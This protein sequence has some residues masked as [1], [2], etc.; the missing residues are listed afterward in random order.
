MGAFLAMRMVQYVGLAALAVVLAGCAQ[1]RQ[2]VPG[3]NVTASVVPA[4]VAASAGGDL[5]V[6]IASRQADAIVSHAARNGDVDTY[7]AV[8]RISVS[9]RQGVLVATRGLGFDLMAGDAAPVLE[10]LRN[11]GAEYS[12][13]MRYLTGLHGS[14]WI[15]AGCRMVVAGSVAGAGTRYEEHCVARR[16]R[17][18]NVY[19][20]DAGGRIIA[21]RQWVSADVGMLETASA[22]Q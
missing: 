1:L 16:D 4:A 19:W 11:P 10:A 6:R 5:R 17:F 15:Q 3:A 7:M 20:L 9:Y 8:D 21:S 22:G 13:Q 14:T 12:R 18:T 2:Q